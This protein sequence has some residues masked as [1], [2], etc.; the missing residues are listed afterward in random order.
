[1]LKAYNFF[2]LKYINIVLGSGTHKINDRFSLCYERMRTSDRVVRHCVDT[3]D[4]QT[5]RETESRVV[6]LYQI[7]IIHVDDILQ[8]V[9]F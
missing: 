1:M 9:S 4:R 3:R 6:D 8:F 2:W 7:C 5:D